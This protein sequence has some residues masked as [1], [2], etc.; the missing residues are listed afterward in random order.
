MKVGE[1]FATLGLEV[2]GASFTAGERAL[3]GIKQGLE[4]LAVFEGVRKITEMIEATSNAAEHAVKSAEKLGTTT[5]AIQE[6]GYAAE[7]TKI[8]ASQLEGAMLRMSRSMDQAQTKGKGPFADAMRKL[9]VSMQD[10]AIK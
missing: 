2:D 7:A 1:L 3:H 9:G 8:P 10:P 5:E 4:A 6:L